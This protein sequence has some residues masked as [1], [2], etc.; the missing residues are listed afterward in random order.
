MTFQPDAEGNARIAVPREPSGSALRLVISVDPI[1][2][3]SAAERPSNQFLPVPD[4]GSNYLF[5]HEI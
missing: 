4:Q 2:A 1:Q 3:G 5:F